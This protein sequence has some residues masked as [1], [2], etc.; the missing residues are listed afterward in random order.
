[1]TPLQRA[2][3][4]AEI[5]RVAVLVG[6]HL[7][8]DVARIDDRFLD[9]N[10]AVAERALRLAA[11]A[12]ERRLQFFGRVHET[13]AFAA[14]ASRGLQ[15]H[16]IADARRNFFGL[17]E[18]F[19][20]SRCA[21]NKGNAR[22]LHRLSRAGFRAH[23]VHRRGGGADELHARL[24]AGARELRILGK[25]SVAGMNGVRAGAR[26]NVENLLDVEIRFGRGGRADG[27]RF[28]GFANVQRRRDPRPSRRQPRQFPSR[29]RRG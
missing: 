22:A 17:L 12:L 13:H 27:I 10:F 11:R 9:V 5:H 2:L 6:Q 21:G 3:A 28:V 4:L 25:K 24:S 16:R 7:H 15:H 18:R 1:M 29:G 19:Q 8:L 26:G 14:A 23:G 20:A